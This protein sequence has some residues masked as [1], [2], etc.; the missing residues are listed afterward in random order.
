M[1]NCQG[2]LL[3]YYLCLLFYSGLKFQSTNLK[4]DPGYN[5]YPPVVSRPG[6]LAISLAFTQYNTND[7]LVES[8]KVHDILE[9]SYQ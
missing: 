6:V 7:R 1:M 8:G 5:P 9:I 3:A 4:V 2:Q